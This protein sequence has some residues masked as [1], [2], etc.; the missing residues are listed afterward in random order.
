MESLSKQQKDEAV[1]LL[2]FLKEKDNGTVKGHGCADG[3][4]QRN[5]YKKEVTAL[6]TVATESVL[7]TAVIGNKE[8]RD[9]AVVD[10]PGAFLQ[11]DIDEDVWMALDGNLSEL[12]FKVS[13]N[14][15]SKFVTTNKNGKKSII[16]QAPKGNL[17]ADQK[18]ITVLQKTVKGFKKDGI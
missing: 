17:R 7:M 3:K 18:R 15:Y 2:M 13:P 14:M 10:I 4:K 1:N 12:M 9:V 8:N 11:A 6:P 16:R 5:K